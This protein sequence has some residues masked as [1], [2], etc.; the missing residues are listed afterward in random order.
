MYSLWVI[1]LLVVL[2]VSQQQR[3]TW[4]ALQLLFN[5]SHLKG[6]Y[7]KP[8]RVPLNLFYNLFLTRVHSKPRTKFDH[9]HLSSSYKKHT[10]YMQLGIY[11]YGFIYIH[12]YIHTHIFVYWQLNV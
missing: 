11:V 7:K 3:N 2:L 1:G 9:L 10:T 12:T 8:L 6:T 5:D 4:L